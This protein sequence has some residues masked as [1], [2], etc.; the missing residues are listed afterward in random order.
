MRKLLVVFL[1]V[2]N[3]SNVNAQ[4]QIFGKYTENGKIE[5]DFNVFGYGAK[6]DTGGQF[7]ISYFFLVEEKWAEGLVGFSYTPTK[8]CELSLQIGIETVSSLYRTSSSIWLGNNK[9][10]FFTCIEKGVGHDNWW[11]K[12]TLE[13]S[14]NKSVSLG[15]ISWRYNGTGVS[16]KYTLNGVSVWVNPAYDLEFKVKRF[17]IGLNLKI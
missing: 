3:F 11:Y 2:V 12:S 14:L 15:L 6:L 8:W 17:T 4:I 16:L 7:K 10:S 9:V 1:L 13:Y 5:P